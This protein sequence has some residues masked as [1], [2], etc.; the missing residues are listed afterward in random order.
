MDF[1]NIRLG[2]INLAAMLIFLVN[3]ALAGLATFFQKPNWPPTIVLLIY[4]PLV[5]TAFF[6]FIS[7]FVS[8]SGK[9]NSRCFGA[10]AGVSALY[11][12]AAYAIEYQ[13]AENFFGPAMMLFPLIYGAIFLVTFFT[14]WS[15]G[16]KY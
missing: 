4:G 10:A 11:S 9:V 16:K 2:P 7:S 12:G 5:V 15:T 14:L 6:S 1:T 8:G 13:G 3:L